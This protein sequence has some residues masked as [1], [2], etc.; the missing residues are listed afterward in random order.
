MMTDQCSNKEASEKSSD[1]K[2]TAV[3]GGAFRSKDAQDKKGVERPQS[4]LQDWQVGGLHISAASMPSWLAPGHGK[5]V[6][7]FLC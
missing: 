2:T 3:Y 1:A 7:I 6:F 5:I 4:G